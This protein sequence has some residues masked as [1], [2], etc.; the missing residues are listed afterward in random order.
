LNPPFQRESV[1]QEVNRQC[2]GTT[3][4]R[5]RWKEDRFRAFSL[6]LPP[7]PEQ[8]RIVDLI[9]ALDDAI[10]AAQTSLATCR[11]TWSLA[12]SQFDSDAPTAPLHDLFAHIIGGAWGDAPGASDTAV[13][14]LGP[15]SYAGRISVDASAAAPRSLSAA[16]AAE[17]V[18]RDG[19]IVLERS[20]GSPTQP[21][22][23]V[24]RMEG[25]SPSNIVPSDFQR[26]LRPAPATADPAYVFWKMWLN[27]ELG[28][29]LPFQKA[30]TSI[31]NLNIPAYLA[32]VR[33]ALP[34]RT[35]QMRFV[36][37]AESFAD[38]AEKQ[39][40]LANRLTEL[41]ADLLTALLSG[42]H[43]IPESYDELME[44]A[45]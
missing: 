40:G 18:L 43:E 45:S 28:A 33:I 27:Y 30:T 29:P 12:L 16:R 15:K 9:G 2:T 8:R 21:V 10:T 32:N 41:R 38:A 35:E 7:I 42:E 1:W 13:L 11:S 14:A 23:R 6:A 22:G 19:D 44:V 39:A 31:R 24:I 3:K 25:N 17:R 37:L 20:G 5:L 4:S 34:D 26:L 36:Q